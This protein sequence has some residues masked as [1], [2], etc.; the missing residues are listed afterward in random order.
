MDIFVLE[1]RIKNHNRFQLLLAL[2]FVILGTALWFVSYWISKFLLFMPLSWFEATR[3]IELATWGFMAL[4]AFEGFR[5]SRELFDLEAMAKAHFNGDFSSTREADNLRAAAWLHYGVPDP[6]RVG[7]V[8]SDLLLAAPRLTLKAWACLRSLV[9][10]GPIEAERAETL[11][12]D[13]ARERGWV[14]MTPYLDH[15][16]EL[17]TL[18][19]MKLLWSRI[20]DD[21]PEV[22]VPPSLGELIP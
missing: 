9:K 22:R 1:T 10:L 21:V 6:F 13:L 8:V 2:L 14:D 15:G 20:Q 16:E 3:H 19:K 4:L 12:Y 11:F 5:Y 7:K 18:H 17:R